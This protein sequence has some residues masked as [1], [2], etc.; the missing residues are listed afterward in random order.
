MSG[1]RSIGQRF[2]RGIERFWLSGPEYL[3]LHFDRLVSDRDWSDLMLDYLSYDS[4]ARGRGMPAIY[5]YAPG[6]TMA[7]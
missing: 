5:A 1:R 7:A 4:L 2:G 3:R 6:E